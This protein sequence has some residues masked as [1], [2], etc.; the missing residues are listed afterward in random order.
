MLKVVENIPLKARRDIALRCRCVVAGAS[1]I[2]HYR[3]L[4]HW[5]KST[6]IIKNYGFWRFKVDPWQNLTNYTFRFHTRQGLPWKSF[7]GVNFVDFSDDT[8]R[9]LG[10]QFHNGKLD[11]IG[12]YLIIYGNWPQSRDEGT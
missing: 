9:Y 7:T 3:N 5:L 11:R 8:S 6:K 4:V 10:T 12:K 2:Y 1:P